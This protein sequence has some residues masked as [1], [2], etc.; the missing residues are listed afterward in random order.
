MAR[1]EQKTSGDFEP[2]PI[3]D[4]PVRAVVVDVT[5]PV[6]QQTDWGEKERIRIVYETE[7]KDKDGNP[8]Y[9]WSKPMSL[10]LAGAEGKKVS[11]LRTELEKILGRKLE[12]NETFDTDQVPNPN[13]PTDVQIVGKPV[14]LIVEH[15]QRDGNVYADITF[16]GAHKPEFGEPYRACGKFVRKKD[17]QEKQDGG[18]SYQKAPTAQATVPEAAED[19][20]KTKVHVGQFAGSTLGEVPPEAVLRLH[21]KWLPAVTAADYKQTADDRRLIAALEKAVAFINQAKAPQP[22]ATDY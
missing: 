9:V 18:A 16:L 21:E 6:K 19:F 10:S 17:R 22:A 3:T 14:R 20:T 7:V 5:P 15:T 13:Y 4:N 8:C 1:I 11:A 12:A 2:H